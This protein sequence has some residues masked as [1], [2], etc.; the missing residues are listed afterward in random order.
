PIH[1]RVT[2]EIPAGAAP[3]PEHVVEA[4]G[5]IRIMTGA[6]MP[7]GADAVVRFEETDEFAHPS[8]RNG[9]AGQDIGVTRAAKP[10]D[11]VRAAGEDI[12]R[13]S[14]V[15]VKGSI[16]RAAALGL[17][18]SVNRSTVSVYRQP[19][20][21][22]LST[23]NEVV[24]LDEQLRPGKIRNSNGYT[25]AAMVADAG[26]IPISLGIAPD[27]LSSL[28]SKLAQAR[29][30]SIDLILTSGGVSLGDY[31][32]VKDALQAEGQIALWQV[33]MKPGKPLAFGHIQ[34]TP[35][36]G[37]PGNPVAAAVSFL[38]F[39]RPAIRKMLGHER[40][41]LAT[42]QATLTHPVNNRGRR[43]HYVRAHFE[44]NGLGGY[45]VRAIGDQGAGVLSSLAQSNGLLVIPEEVDEAGAGMVCEVQLLPGAFD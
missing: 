23:G 24:D 2:G 38:Q 36:L 45:S 10:W 21:A 33:R 35:L 34:E 14:L 1:L 43:R 11:N 31:D 32:M 19:R 27:D 29:E 41:T 7:P 18:A 42:I 8:N 15:L 16:L 20:V 30:E 37:L 25:L 44:S 9:R 6:P 39:G 26:G 28:T 17:L 40:L 12:H 13:G 4:G 3:D 22:V 5:A